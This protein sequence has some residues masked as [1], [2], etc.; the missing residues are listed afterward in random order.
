[1]PVP[2]DYRRLGGLF[3]KAT[4]RTLPFLNKC[5]DTKYLAVNDFTQAKNEYLELALQAFGEQG[6]FLRKQAKCKKQLEALRIALESGN[7]G[8]DYVGALQR[9]RSTY[10][11][12]VLKP[13]V[14]S[15]FDRGASP[16]K[17]LARLYENALRIDGLLELIQFLGKVKSV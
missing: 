2:E 8:E 7:L 14:K 16:K 1:M 3:Q 10:L 17:E 6:I 9:F 15:Y 11:R 13:A 4:N 5:S 12:E